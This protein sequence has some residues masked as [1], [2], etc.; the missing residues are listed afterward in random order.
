MDAPTGKPLIDAGVK[1]AQDSSRV[2]AVLTLLI[3]ALGPAGVLLGLEVGLRVF[4]PQIGPP[5]A[6]AEPDGMVS[7]RPNV[8]TVW[9]GAEFRVQIDTDRDGHPRCTSRGDPRSGDSPIL[10]LSALREDAVPYDA[11]HP[12]AHPHPRL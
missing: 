2:F 10:L 11:F 4:A 8:H 6:Y 12:Q 3:G 5:I 7:H 1:P 9:A